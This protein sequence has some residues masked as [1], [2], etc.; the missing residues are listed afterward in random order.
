MELF[1]LLSD[2]DFDASLSAISASSQPTTESDDLIAEAG[3]SPFDPDFTIDFSDPPSSPQSSEHSIALIEDISDGDGASS[4]TTPGTVHQLASRPVHSRARLGSPLPPHIDLD[5]AHDSVLVQFVTHQ[6]LRAAFLAC[7]KRHLDSVKQTHTGLLLPHECLSMLR[8]EA[9]VMSWMYLLQ[10]VRPG[11]AVD[12]LGVLVPNHVLT[13]RIYLPHLS[14]LPALWHAK[15]KAFHT[16][17]HHV[18]AIQAIGDA[19][20]S[21]FCRC[22]CR[23]CR[24]LSFT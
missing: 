15:A 2:I 1:N 21:A 16:L 17:T 13:H 24:R 3:L 5:A 9:R 22:D 4:V 8:Y 6:T 23:V 19:T 12:A 10:H 11:G 7:L 14:T 18:D 20:A